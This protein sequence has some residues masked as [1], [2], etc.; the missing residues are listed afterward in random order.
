MQVVKKINNNVAMCIDGNGQELIAFG[1]GIGFPKTPYELTDMGKITRTYYNVDASMYGLLNEIPVEIF[2]ISGR[3]V[4]IAKAR[5]NRQFNANMAFSLADHINFAIQRA[6]K[7]INIQ[8]AF[9]YDVE[10]LYP[11]EMELGKLALK[12]IRESCKIKLPMNEGT[13]IA[14]HFINA[15]E[16]LDDDL[17]EQEFDQMVESMTKVLEQ[18][19]KVNIDRTSFDYYR[20]CSHLRYFL[21]RLRENA[22]FEDQDMELFAYI[23]N[24]Y[25]K[26]CKCVEK[27]ISCLPDNLISECNEQ[28]KLYLTIYV[29]RLCN[30]Q[31]G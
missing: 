3:L 11:V 6:Q 31:M 20:F 25:P 21:K 1:N 7:G 16:P 9:S 15:E 10:T 26:A 12:M 24:D 22:A 14:L 23:Q 28:E 8:F 27:M 29:I 5:L 4:D 30:N 17:T 13:S 2:E 18:Y 19:F